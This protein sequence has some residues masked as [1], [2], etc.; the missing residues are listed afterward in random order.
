MLFRKSKRLTVDDLVEEAELRELNL[1]QIREEEAELWTPLPGPQAAAL[2][3]PADELFYGGAAGGGKTDLILG[4]ACTR[5]RRS[6]VFRREYPHLKNIVE[7][8]REILSGTTAR[9]IGGQDRTWKHIPG[10]R[11]IEFGAVQYETDKEN[12]KG[13]PHDLIAFDELPDFLESQ[14]RFLV[15]WLRTPIVGQRCRVIA[16]GNPPTHADGEWVLRRWGP[17]LDRQHPNPAKPGELRWYA[18]VDG[19]DVERENG[20]PFEWKGETIKPKSR[21]FIPAFV[22]DNPYYMATDYVSQ[23]QS[24]PEP[25]RTQLLKG[26]FSIGI[27][28]A[29]WQVVPTAWVKAAQERWTPDGAAQPCTAVGVDV[30]RGGKDKTVL[31][32][33]HGNWFRE[34]EK[35]PGKSTPDGRVVAQL[36]AETRGGGTPYIDVIG[37][38]AA[39]YDALESI[40]VEAV[41]VNVASAAREKDKTGNF[42]FINLRA[43]L[44]WKFREAL[45]PASGIDIALPPDRELLADLTA[46][47]YSRSARGIQVESKEDIARRLGRSTDCGDAVVIA[48]HGAGREGDDGECRAALVFLSYPKPDF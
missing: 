48:W 47:R 18:V 37:V 35:H 30:A 45:D 21:T 32:A 14:Y 36:V 46:P 9:Y 15:G 39:A 11:M 8:S 6:I 28:D 1:R 26:D 17:W 12:Y 10:G 7:R 5:H 33:V 24:L 2:E 3:T 31:A 4:A 19:E 43:Q 16:S 40:G 42:G 23:L 29:A 34:L 27:G 44:Y 25:L 38:G 13:R 20:D 41:P 22:T